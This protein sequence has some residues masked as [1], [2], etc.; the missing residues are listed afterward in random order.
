[1]QVLQTCFAVLICLHQQQLLTATSTATVYDDSTA[2]S[3]APANRLNTKQR[4]VTVSTNLLHPFPTL[5][6]SLS[7]FKDYLGSSLHILAIV[8]NAL[9]PA[10]TSSQQTP[11]S[12]WAWFVWWGNIAPLL[13][14]LLLWSKRIAEWHIHSILLR[15]WFSLHQM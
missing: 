4:T 11:A 8:S 1:M 13:R 9:P 2:T 15:D 5:F 10:A 7:V 12:V 6:T 14:T 3:T